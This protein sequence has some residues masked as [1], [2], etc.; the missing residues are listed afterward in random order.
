MRQLKGSR[1]E[2][3]L[4]AALEREAQDNRRFEYFARRAAVEGRLGAARLFRQIAEGETAHAMGHLEF[5]EVIDDPPTDGEVGDMRASLQAAI[6]SEKRGCDRYRAFATVARDEGLTEV[7]E[8]FDMLAQAKR[9]YVGS[10]VRALQLLPDP[11]AGAP[12]ERASRP[13]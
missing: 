8:W 3:N 7:A 12:P 9:A 6:A 11:D 1:T 5:L 13:H 2:E 4:R 10:L